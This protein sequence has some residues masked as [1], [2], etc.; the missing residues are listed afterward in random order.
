MFFIFTLLIINSILVIYTIINKNAL[1]LLISIFISY[2]ALFFGIVFLSILTLPIKLLIISFYVFYFIVEMIKHFIFKFNKYRFLSVSNVSNYTIDENIGKNQKEIVQFIKEKINGDISFHNNIEIILNSEDFINDLLTEIEKAEKYILM[3]FYIFSNDEISKKII[4]KLNYALKRCV[5]V[6]IIIDSIGSIKSKSNFFAEYKNLGGKIVKYGILK[7]GSLN[8]RNHKK[9]IVIDGNFFYTGGYN[10]RSD[11]FNY[12]DTNKNWQDLE[13]KITGDSV[14]F[15]HQYYMQD[16]KF[17][18]YEDLNIYY[19]DAIS[20]ENNIVAL[21]NSN[22]NYEINKIKNLYFKL[23]VNAKKNVVI[24]TPYLILNKSFKELM[25]TLLLSGVE[26]N[27]II[28]KIPDKKLVYLQT[29][30]NAIILCNAGAKIYL[31]NGFLHSKCLIIDN[32]ICSLGSVNFDKRSFN[33]NSEFTTIFWNKNIIEKI[34]ENFE[35]LAKN[36]TILTQE[37]YDK[38]FKGKYIGN[39]TSILLEK[40]M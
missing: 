39:F 1:S 27:I 8:S 29:L 22:P 38:N 32:N 24:Y 30:K 14:K 15:A 19:K 20:E 36:S 3:E 25:Q 11:H 28:P 34:N 35:E 13:I 12:G 18:T 2:I 9:L 17:C 21:I 10:I 23:L 37:Y 6:V 7:N 5:K 31:Y 4:E 26:I 33:I 40:F 16:Y